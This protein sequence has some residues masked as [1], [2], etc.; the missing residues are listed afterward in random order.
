MVILMH[1]FRVDRLGFMSA[2]DDVFAITVSANATQR[3]L[4]VLFY[5]TNSKRKHKLA[6]TCHIK[7]GIEIFAPR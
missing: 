4:L 6:K 7:S 1:G 5:V 2:Y 3:Y